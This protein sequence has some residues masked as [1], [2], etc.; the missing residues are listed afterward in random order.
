MHQGRCQHEG[1]DRDHMCASGCDFR[2]A[3]TACHPLA[4]IASPSGVTLS[5]N[6]AHPFTQA[7]APTSDLLLIDNHLPSGSQSPV[8]MVTLTIS[9]TYHSESR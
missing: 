4:V 5:I 2:Y 7:W 9:P 3:N 8:V 6:E 1:L